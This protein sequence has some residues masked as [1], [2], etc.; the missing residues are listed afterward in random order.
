MNTSG[1]SKRKLDFE[2]NPRWGG[3]KEKEGRGNR[4]GKNRREQIILFFFWCVKNLSFFFKK[5]YF[6]SSSSPLPFSSLPPPPSP[7]F[8]ERDEMRIWGGLGRKG[9][10]GSNGEKPPKF[11][12]KTKIR[13]CTCGGEEKG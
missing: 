11:V 12:E 6:L 5:K 2:Q 4:G 9:R 10:T 7:H 13:K 8:L 1:D 3:G